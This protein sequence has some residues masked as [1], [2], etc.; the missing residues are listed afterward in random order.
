MVRPTT[1]TFTV[2]ASLLLSQ[3]ITA[4]AQPDDDSKKQAALDAAAPADDGT[5]VGVCVDQVIADR[6]AQKR[7]RR[8]AIDR[9][10]IKQA[11]HEITA[12][13]GYYNSDLFSSTYVVGGTYTFHMT[14]Q[15]AVEFAGAYTHANADVI[16]A[17]EDK[18]GQLLSNTYE[19]VVFAE[20]ALV[21]SPI[22]GKLRF[23][24]AVRHFDIDLSLGVG[25]VDSEASRGA[26]G[27]LGVGWKL[28][29]GQAWAFRLDFRN[30][31]FY[32]DLL[33]QRQLV[34]DST[35]TAGISL[36]LPFTP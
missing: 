28:F 2:F 33:D 18:R 7:K 31:T 12:L 3:A 8:G 24:G 4:Q 36:F 1:L 14:E 21:W 5:A 23:G 29:A 11:R 13:G 17:L 35:V 6:L 27:V 10:F 32:Q 20:A 25:V 26:S 16:R 34:N 15:T 9:L 30:R 19:R 22:Y